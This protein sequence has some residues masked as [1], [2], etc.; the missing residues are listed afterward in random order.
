MSLAVGPKRSRA[1]SAADDAGHQQF[2]EAWRTFSRASERA[3]SRRR[4]N[5]GDGALSLPQTLLLSGLLHEPELPV[6]VLADL[7]MVAKPTATRMLDALERE[8]YVE[9]RKCL[10]DRR[11][12]LISLT[13]EG[14]RV[15]DETWSHLH[16]GLVRASEALSDRERREATALLQRLAQVMDEI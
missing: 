3:K 7:A 9:R 13:E 12:V 1:A 11:A 4:A 6:G 2:I 15:L 16:A 5:D 8:G 14:R 10:T